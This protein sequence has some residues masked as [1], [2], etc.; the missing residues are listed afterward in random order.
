MEGGHGIMHVDIGER[1]LLLLAN[2]PFLPSLAVDAVK[3]IKG[4]LVS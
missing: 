3:G 2:G 1:S 4:P